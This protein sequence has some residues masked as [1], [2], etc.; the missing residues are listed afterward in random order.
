MADRVV[1]KRGKEPF[2]LAEYELI[3]DDSLG[4][5]VMCYGWLIPDDHQLYKT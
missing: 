5:T 4:F 1:L 2:C 3:V